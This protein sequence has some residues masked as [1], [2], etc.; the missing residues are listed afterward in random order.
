MSL[1]L[2]LAFIVVWCCSVVSKRPRFEKKPHGGGDNEDRI[3]GDV[4]PEHE[5]LI[6][7]FTKIRW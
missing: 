1:I 2:A 3:L 6:N 5:D 4:G 7:G